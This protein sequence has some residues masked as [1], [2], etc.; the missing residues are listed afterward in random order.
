ME[1]VKAIL[2]CIQTHA[3]KLFIYIK[4][5]AFGHILRDNED[6]GFL[7]KKKTSPLGFF[8]HIAC[9]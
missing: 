3:H 7:H 2:K 1:N 5:M 8:V 4:F 6:E 9:S